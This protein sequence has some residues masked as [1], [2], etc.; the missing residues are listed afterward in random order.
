[1][2]FFKM[3]NKSALN[4]LRV[5]FPNVSKLNLTANKIA[6]RKHITNSKGKVKDIGVHFTEYKKDVHDINSSNSFTKK[7]YTQLYDLFITE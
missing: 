6:I 1:M 5:K 7:C 2:K 4:K 3:S